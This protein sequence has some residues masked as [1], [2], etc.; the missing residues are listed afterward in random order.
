MEQLRAGA[1][2]AKLAHGFLAIDPAANGGLVGW[3]RPDQVDDE[4]R[5]RDGRH[6][7]Q[8]R[9]SGPIRATAATTS[10]NSSGSGRPAPSIRTR[11]SSVLKQ[12]FVTAPSN[13]PKPSATRP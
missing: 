6:E 11:R 2:F 13:Q 8:A 1:D 5:E 10:S 3:V 4:T 9:C 7:I 12:V